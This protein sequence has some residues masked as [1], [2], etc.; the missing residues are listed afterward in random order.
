MAQNELQKLL[1]NKSVVVVGRAPYLLKQLNGEFIDSHDIVVR[2][3]KP[4]PWGFPK[5]SGRNLH[6]V[7][8]NYQQII[9][10]RTDLLYL[11]EG[12]HKTYVESQLLDLFV[13]DG[14]KVVISKQMNRQSWAKYE[15]YIKI[16]ESRISYNTIPKQL[17]KKFNDEDFRLGGHKI[18]KDGTSFRV[19]AMSGLN[20]V[21][22]CL[23][24]DVQSVSAIGF[25]C[26]YGYPE[27][28]RITK[29]HKFHKAESDL[30]WFY[31]TSKQDSRL[32][33]DDNL[34][35]VFEVQTEVLKEI[36]GISNDIR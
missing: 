2:V 1:K 29:E 15:Q 5:T 11:N 21:R 3:N 4:L 16:I 12:E 19:S 22:F 10:T 27:Y 17:N 7:D 26:G 24:F 6:Y 31:T 30:Y 35:S 25:T 13:K 36:G 8:R 14:G 23:S 33:L 18:Y 9:G 20:T 34:K 32:I 28:L